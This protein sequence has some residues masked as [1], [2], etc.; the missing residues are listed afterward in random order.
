MT[1]VPRQIAVASE[2][3]MIVYTTCASETTAVIVAPLSAMTDSI[4]AAVGG[5]IA[6]SPVTTNSMSTVTEGSEAVTP[7]AA[8]ASIPGSVA[9]AVANAADGKFSTALAA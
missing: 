1:C 3:G 7:A 4:A 9:R 2:H 5:T 6:A 8:E